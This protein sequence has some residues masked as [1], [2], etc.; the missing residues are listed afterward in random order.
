MVARI[1]AGCPKFLAFILCLLACSSHASA[2]DWARKMFS[3]QDHDFG[4]VPR[5][6]KAEY[7][8]K[9][10][11]SYE[12]PLHVAAVRS[13][14][15]CTIPR[16]LDEKRDIK[17]YQEG[18]IVCE[19][20]TRSFIGTKEAVVTVVFDRPV[21]AEVQ[22]RVK[23]NIRSDIVTE[24]GEIQFGELELGEEAQQKVRIT[25]AGRNYWE[26][27]DVRSDNEN[28]G[29]SFEGDPVRTRDGRV[30]Y[31]M[32][33]RLKGSA[34][35]GLMNSQIYLVTNERLYNSVNIP[36]RGSVL[37]PLAVTPPEPI[38]T[39]DA[40]D[41]WTG[42]IVLKS[43]QAFAIK[44]VDCKDDRFQFEIPTGQKRLHLIRVKFAAGAEDEGA[45]K[46]AVRITTDLPKDGVAET[47]LSGN[48][49]A[50]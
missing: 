4:I 9:F 15:G 34:P 14:C 33:V 13:S 7:V 11:N 42:R 23:G 5:G 49:V 39:V 12:Q 41:E 50:K 28:L 8:F 31:R 19:F 29:V 32:N 46:E 40:G 27:T 45:F 43:K 30:E 48:V 37:P 18:G 22:L 3:E 17:T 21:Y 24:P 26:I 47:A 35:A 20:N 1:E 16:V 44:E 25:Y 6:A 38:G 36:V 10:T 2:Q